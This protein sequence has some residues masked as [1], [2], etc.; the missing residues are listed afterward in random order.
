MGDGRGERLKGGGVSWLIQ[1][2]SGSE[3]LR[4][5]LSVLFKTTESGAGVLN[6]YQMPSDLCAGREVTHSSISLLRRI[7]TS[8]FQQFLC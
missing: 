2:R 6:C 7:T 8:L 5:F 1:E 3:F 4:K